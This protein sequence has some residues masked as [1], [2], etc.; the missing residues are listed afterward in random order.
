MAMFTAQK[1]GHCSL[2]RAS[3]MHYDISTFNSKNTTWTNNKAM[4]ILTKD[5]T[6]VG[7]MELL[8]RLEMCEGVNATYRMIVAELQRR[9]VKAE[10]P[11]MENV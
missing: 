10:T 3:S 4:D 5:L 8:K 7:T 9:G 1:H 2:A 6:A 11:R